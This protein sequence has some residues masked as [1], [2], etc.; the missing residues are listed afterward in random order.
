M[1]PLNVGDVEVTYNLFKNLG[2]DLITYADGGRE[3]TSEEKQKLFNRVL[4]QFGETDF[5]EY[6]EKL[7]NLRKQLNTSPI[8]DLLSTAT[9]ISGLED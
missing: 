7:I 5:S 3:L 9:E 6:L 4:P 1:Q 8:Y 2:G